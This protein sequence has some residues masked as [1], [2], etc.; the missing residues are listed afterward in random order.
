VCWVPQVLKEQARRYK[1]RAQDAERQAGS[2]EQQ[3][4]ALQIA[5]S[6]LKAQLHEGALEQ[7]VSEAAQARQQAEGLAKALEVGVFVSVCH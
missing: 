2:V 6:K 4:L 7:D 5:N 1:Q 3:L